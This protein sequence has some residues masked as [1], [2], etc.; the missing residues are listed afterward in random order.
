MKIRVPSRASAIWPW[1]GLGLA[2]GVTA[3]GWSVVRKAE[4]ARLQSIFEGE[5]TAR[6]TMISQRVATENQILKG[7]AEFISQKVN[8]SRDDWRDYVLAL[9][10]PRRYPGIQGLGFIKWVPRRDLGAHEQW[11]RAEGW[12]GYR[13]KPMAGIPPDSE[14][15]GPVV[16][17][18]PMT[19]PNRRVLGQDV[20]SEPV[21]QEAFVRSR[22]LGQVAATRQIYLFQEGATD[23][24]C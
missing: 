4:R 13:V 2:L 1:V 10:L 18:E 15:F 22:D 3:G 19:E 6:V 5:V 14:G 9:E 24:Q 23:R 11:A 8:L 7:A 21:R 17:M 16:F 12:Q 20:W